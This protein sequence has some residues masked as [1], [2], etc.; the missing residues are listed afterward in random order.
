MY[1]GQELRII[2][3]V[4]I[5]TY[6]LP[7]LFICILWKLKYIRNLDLSE[8]WERTF[9]YLIFMMAN[10]S[11]TYFFYSASMYF[12][13]LG[14]VIAPAFIALIGFIINYFW[15]ISA[16]MLGIGGLIG[17][18]MSVCYNVK[19]VNPFL[20]FIILFLLAG[21][22]GTARLYLRK[23]TAAQIYMGFIIGF[24]IGF[25]SVL[26]AVFTSILAY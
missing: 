8:Q 19:G 23:S 7:G 15:K 18:L 10:I 13:F 12:W 4:F 9:P 17:G 2:L 24:I 1:E 21:G 6:I 25:I 26:F 3:P 14:L 11:L 16:H 20:L 5:F 22:L